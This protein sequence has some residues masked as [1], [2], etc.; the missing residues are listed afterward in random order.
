[1]EGVDISSKDE[2]GASVKEKI[3]LPIYPGLYLCQYLN[4]ILDKISSAV[5]TEVESVLT[6]ELQIKW[7]SRLVQRVENIIAVPVFDEYDSQALTQLLFDI[8]FLT[9]LFDFAV[10]QESSL[11]QQLSTIETRISSKMD[12]IE[13]AVIEPYLNTNVSRYYPRVAL[14]FAILVALNSVKSEKRYATSDNMRIN[15]C[16]TSDNSYQILGLTPHRIRL[17]IVT[18]IEKNPL[19]T[20]ITAGKY[21]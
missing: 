2:Q 3:Y 20:A 12:P 21:L 14:S 11:S 19:L 8:R 18:M 4:E 16:S 9:S 5:G 15:P 6:R 1:M 13:L 17:P 7:A 10:H